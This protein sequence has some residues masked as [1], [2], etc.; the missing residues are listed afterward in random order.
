MSALLTGEPPAKLAGATVNDLFTLENY[1][2]WPKELRAQF[3]EFIK[4]TNQSDPAVISMI[5]DVALMNY[6]FAVEQRS[7]LPT[8]QKQSG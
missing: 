7:V 2:A 3:E 5:M 4:L 6:R 1:D 8:E